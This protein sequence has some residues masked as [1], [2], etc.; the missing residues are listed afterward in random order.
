M[1]EKRLRKRVNITLPP[2]LNERWNLVAKK[3]HI[4]KSQMVE[5]FLEMVLPVLEADSSG[6]VVKNA[7][8]NNF[9]NLKD[10]R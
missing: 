2:L 1:S 6:G 5:E 3:H 8:K 9:G 7:L 10:I 4:K